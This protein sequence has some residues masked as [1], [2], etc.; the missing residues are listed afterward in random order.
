MFP[1]SD[2][3]NAAL[4]GD[5]FCHDQNNNA[6]CNFDGGDCCL[7]VNT[8]QCLECTCHH[9]EN[10][11]TGFIPSIVGDGICDD[12]TNN[13]ICNYDG[14]DCCINQN[15]VANGF[16]NDETNHLGCNY[17]GGD[18]CLVNHNVGFLHILIQKY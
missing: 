13:G 5:G 10:C 12:E 9:T 15:V 2:C 16:C 8:S 4:V 11:A 3:L 18:C 6:E 17:D 7:N 14:G 1:F